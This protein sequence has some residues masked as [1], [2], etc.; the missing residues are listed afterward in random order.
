MA[1]QV[2]PDHLARCLAPREALLDERHETALRLFNGFSEGWPNLVIDL[3]ATTAVINNH[4][5]PPDEGLDVIRAAQDFLQSHLPWLSACLVKTRNS[6]LPEERRGR[7]LFGNEAAHKIK[8]HGIWYALNLT[9]HQDASLYLDTRNLRRWALE[10]LE[11]RTVLNTFAYTGSLGVAALAGK[12][13]RVV[14][15]DRNERFLNVGKTSYLLNGFPIDQKDFIRADFFRQAGQFKRTGQLFDCVFVDPPYFASSTGGVVDQV[16]DSA[17]LINKVRPLVTDGGY[18]VAINNALYVSGS[19]YMRTLDELCADGYL[20][21]IE[22]I[23]VPADITGYPE[24]RA[25]APITDPAPFNYA[26]KIA[27][28]KARRKQ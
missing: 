3:Y 18:L 22:L 20:K 21:I 17:R 28:L 14:Q 10:R 25:G 23:P 27:V 16:R 5:D 24:T 6:K 1:A 12:A 2:L 7:L 4:A 13:S 15:L 19:D 11:G 9:M 8:E 26:T